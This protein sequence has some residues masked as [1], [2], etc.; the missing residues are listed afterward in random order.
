M[1]LNSQAS[2]HCKHSGRTPVSRN[3]Y[4][5]C[6]PT[7]NG[8]TW[9]RET[10]CGVRSGGSSPSRAPLHSTLPCSRNTA[11]RDWP[12]SSC[13]LRAGTAGP[14]CA[15]TNNVRFMLLLAHR[16][17]RPK[18]ATSCTGTNTCLRKFQNLRVTGDLPDHSLHN[19][20]AAIFT[21]QCKPHLDNT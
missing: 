19:D 3:S 11:D 7:L 21:G 15:V 1:S 10:Q 2:C 14:S 18:S 13:L 4:A 17:H 16:L 9:F 5:A 8:M 12:R 20:P 6:S